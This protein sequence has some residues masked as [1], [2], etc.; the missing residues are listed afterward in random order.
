MAGHDPGNGM[1]PRAAWLLLALVATSAPAGA[2]ELHWRGYLDLRLR[3][4]DGDSSSWRDGGLG[5][6]PGG[7]AATAAVGVTWQPAPAWQVAA[8]WQ[9]DSRATPV[10]GLL[11]GWVRYRPVS[12]TP[13][14]WSVR[15]GSFFPPVS[16]ENDATG[17]TSPW[18]LSPSAINSWVGEELRSTGLEFRLERRFPTGVMEAGLAGFVGNDPAGE[19]LAT[20]GWGIGDAT[21]TLGAWLRQP[22]V[23]APRKRSEPPIQFQPFVET[24]GR[25]GWHADLAWHD[26]GERRIAL[27]HYDNRAD[28]TSFDLQHDRR[29]FSW[30][31]RFT[32]L[33]LRWPLGSSLVIVQAMAGDTAFQPRPD[34]Y[35]STSFDA[36]FLLWAWN[37][38]GRWR[39]A[40]RLDLFRAREAG[41]TSTDLDEHGRALTAS[42]AWR[43]SAQWRLS[44]EWIVLSGAGNQRPLE[45]LPPRGIERQ[46]QLSLRRLF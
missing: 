21:S 8:D 41:A 36:A 35:L 17:W 15:A 18:T 40:V 10:I 25:V 24:D 19:L 44:A 9:L 6:F 2:T 39:P 20:R 13:W 5:K 46:W 1:N 29:V 28:P 4:G 34:R 33:G 23:I 3:A 37:V 16:L 26:G 22:D 30:R 32:S 27:L 12:L 7:S 45:G 43:P 42:L 38:E 11:E 31:T 14:R